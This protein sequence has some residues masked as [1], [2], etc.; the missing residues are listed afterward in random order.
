MSAL[1]DA[2]DSNPTEPR[3]PRPVPR[4][5]IGLDGTTLLEGRSGIGFYTEHLFAGLVSANPGHEFRVFSNVPVRTRLLPRGLIHQGDGFPV[6]GVWLQVLLPF[7]L[8]REKVDVFHYTNYLAPLWSGCPSVVTIHDM[9]LS[10][11]P[12]FFP[13]KKRL[14]LRPLIPWVARRADAIIAVSES[15][16]QDILR[17]IRVPPE[18]VHVIHEGVAPC[19]KPVADPRV[20]ETVKDR[21][22]LDSPYFMAVGTVEPRKNIVRLARAFARVRSEAGRDL[23]LLIVG[24]KGWRSEEILREVRKVAGKS[25]IWTGYAPSDDLPALYSGAIAL[26][27][28]S[29]YEGFGLPVV[30][31]MA[32]GAPVIASDHAAL[33]EVGGGCG[34]LRRPGRR[35]GPGD[36]HEAGAGGQW[37]EGRAPRSGNRPRR[38][39]FVGVGRPEDGRGL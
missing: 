13:W 14:L 22:G 17:L 24:G 33:R 27:Y 2:S 37:A 36:G 39:V 23:R 8:R 9:A 34:A 18:K 1:I 19:F 21:N 3:L 10:L 15:A 38:P 25:V 20:V 6:R 5:R 16:R 31:A 12:G 26:V 4:L 35:G 28:P 30:E 7:L 32:C 29:I 11:L